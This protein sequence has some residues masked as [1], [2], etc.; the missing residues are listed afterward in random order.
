MVG[1]RAS[2][3]WCVYVVENE[4]NEQ[5]KEG[6]SG[7]NQGADEKNVFLWVSVQLS[8]HTHAPS[9]WPVH[10]EEPQAGAVEAVQVVEGV[11]E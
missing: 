2:G 4:H 9:S 8:S 3:G 5:E 10:G 1:R 11:R 7:S 6:R